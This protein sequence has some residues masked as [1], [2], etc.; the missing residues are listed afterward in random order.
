MYDGIGAFTKCDLI[1]DRTAVGAAGI[2]GPAIGSIG[3]AF[4]QVCHQTH[5]SKLNRT[6]VQPNLLVR[7]GNPSEGDAPTSVVVV[8]GRDHLAAE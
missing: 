6:L 4:G 1:I 3:P 2:G 5:F 7:Q 8:V